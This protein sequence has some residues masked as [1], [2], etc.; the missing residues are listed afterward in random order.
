[1][2]VGDDAGGDDGDDVSGEDE[3]DDM[4]NS[5]GHLTP[6]ALNSDSRTMHLR[7]LPARVENPVERQVCSWVGVHLALALLVFVS[8]NIFDFVYL[9]LNHQ[10]NRPHKKF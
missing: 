4:E 6:P 5:D 10:L 8:V 1:M 3:D 7:R 9:Y 2:I